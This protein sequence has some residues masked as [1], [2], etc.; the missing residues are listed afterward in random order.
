MAFRRI[1][2]LLLVEAAI[3]LSGCVSARAE[4]ESD[5]SAVQ[6][7]DWI[8]SPGPWETLQ[9]EVISGAGRSGGDWVLLVERRRIGSILG[10][11][12]EIDVTTSRLR[13]L[14]MRGRDSLKRAV[15][16]PTSNRDLA[17]FAP[18]DPEV[19]NVPIRLT[20]DRWGRWPNLC[21]L[22]ILDAQAGFDLDKDGALEIALRRVCSCPSSECSG[23]AFLSLD[24]DGVRLL[25]PSR[26]VA[27]LDVGPLRVRDIRPGEDPARPILDVAPEMLDGCRFIARL[28]IRGE[29]ECE[30]CCSFPVLI[31]PD[32][33]GYAVFFDRS[34]QM[35]ALRRAEKD[36]GWVAAGN[37][38]E[39][40]RPM[41]LALVARAASFYYLT[42]TGDSAKETIVEILGP[43]A[44]DF[45]LVTLLRRI[46]DLFL[47]PEPG[48]R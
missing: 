43:R 48:T 1:A 15:V 12:A 10:G 41:E 26:L 40:L 37:P 11:R 45:Q 3:G 46:D 23:I 7:A 30:E 28:G 38:V 36:L 20:A 8:A 34:S 21:S 44:R 2:W 33:R 6:E 5:A 29:A 31:R 25:D 13:V 47:A 4:A 14:E 27:G 18:E 19:E 39:P 17:V 42:G 16:L 24:A 35:E 9:R 32:E 22:T